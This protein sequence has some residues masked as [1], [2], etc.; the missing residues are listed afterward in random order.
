MENDGAGRLGSPIGLAKPPL[1]GAERH[2][3]FARRMTMRRVFG[4]RPEQEHAEGDVRGD[5]ERRRAVGG[6]REYCIA[7]VQQKCGGGRAGDVVRV[8][9][10]GEGGPERLDSF[11]ERPGVA[12][13]SASASEKRAAIGSEAPSPARGRAFASASGARSS[14]KAASSG[15]STR[16]LS[17]ALSTKAVSRDR[18]TSS[19]L[20]SRSRP[21]EAF[22]PAPAGRRST[23][24]RLPRSAAR[25]S[26][27]RRSSSRRLCAGG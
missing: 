8:L 24:P 18:L 15:V 2:V 25:G 13:A 22:A 10:K 23:L 12:F 9:R 5:G 3:D 21:T 26:G 4:V 1:G 7:I 11:G 6:A 20:K 16:R 14:R 19:S 17:S 27:E